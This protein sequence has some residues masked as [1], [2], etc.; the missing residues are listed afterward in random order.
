MLPILTYALW[1]LLALSLGAGIVG[2]V[3]AF[4]FKMR[5]LAERDVRA[6]PIGHYRPNPARAV[7]RHRQ[8]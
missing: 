5:E 8:A 3:N 4:R 2:V 6:A 1:L 7:A